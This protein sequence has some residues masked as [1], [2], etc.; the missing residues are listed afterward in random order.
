VPPPSFNKQVPA[1]APCI[2]GKDIRVN[3]M[4]P[5]FACAARWL[6]L[7]PFVL[8]GV[9]ALFWRTRLPERVATHFDGAGNPNG[10]MGRDAALW[11]GL[12]MCVFLQ[13]VF[14]GVGRLIRAV[15]DSM[16]NLPDKDYWL[17][18]ERREA[19]LARIEGMLR[20]M[21]LMVGCFVLAVQEASFRANRAP[22]QR[23]GGDAI[24]LIMGFL[25][26]E[27]IWVVRFL[28]MWNAPRDAR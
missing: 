13:C 16:I 23:L 4:R 12:G 8:A 25:I 14:L 28:A 11:F 26:L 19:T 24:V 27:L 18:P 20:G 2:A 9:Q 21:G 15:P 5:F 7:L 1:T 10:W 3:P 17:A 22:G 6:P